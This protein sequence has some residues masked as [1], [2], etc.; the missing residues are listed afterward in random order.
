MGPRLFTSYVSLRGY[1]NNCCGNCKWR[2]HG[3][4]CGVRRENGDD[5]QKTRFLGGG[6]S[7]GGR[8]IG[9]IEGDEV[10]VDAEE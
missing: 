6:G 10:L 8:A 1:W 7:F 9:E 4:R 5:T 2:D 3:A